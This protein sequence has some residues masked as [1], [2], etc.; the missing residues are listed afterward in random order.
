MT[1]GRVKEELLEVIVRLR[2]I[3]AAIVIRNRFVE[4][5]PLI[6]ALAF[7]YFYSV[8]VFYAEFSFWC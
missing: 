3:L 5:L 6:T 8:V 7:A 4:L 1:L 2:R